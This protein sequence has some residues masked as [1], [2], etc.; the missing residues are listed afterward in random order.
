MRRQI[1]NAAIGIIA[2][3][4][5]GFVVLRVVSTVMGIDDGGPFSIVRLGGIGLAALLLL[6]IVV[7]INLLDLLDDF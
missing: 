3:V 6:G 2:F 1:W 4:L 5:F 7:G